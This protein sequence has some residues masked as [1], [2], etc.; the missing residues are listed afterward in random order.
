MIITDFSN[1]SIAALNNII[2]NL[3]DVVFGHH[4][5]EDGE[6]NAAS[7]VCLMAKKELSIK[8][9]IACYPNSLFSR[10]HNS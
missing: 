4:N 7:D 2:R 10:H 3:E 5:I 9:E 8:I 1:Y 6:R